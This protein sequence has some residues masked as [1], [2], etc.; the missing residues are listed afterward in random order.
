MAMGLDGSAKSARILCLK[1]AQRAP[2]VQ[3]IT[4][5]VRTLLATIHGTQHACVQ[6]ASLCCCS[7]PIACKQSHVL[8]IQVSMDFMANTLLAVGASPAMVHTPAHP[9]CMQRRTTNNKPDLP[10]YLVYQCAAHPTCLAMLVPSQV[11]CKE[12]VEDFMRIASALL[13][14]VGT[15]SADWVESMRLAAA[16]AKELGKPWVLDPV[17]AG[18]TRFRTEVLRFAGP[19]LLHSLTVHACTAT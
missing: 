6:Y 10:K 17:G 2:L 7:T 8:E 4:N 13:V 14:N 12:E 1:M 18:A 16:A 3:C 9:L 5:Y 15:L 19:L 11:H